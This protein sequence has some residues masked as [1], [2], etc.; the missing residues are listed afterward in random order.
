[1]SST[2][3]SDPRQDLARENL[4]SAALP[5][6]S[7]AELDE[8]LREL[9]ER[10]DDVVQDRKRLSLLLD[11]VVVIAAD[12]SLDSVLARIVRVASEL[13]DARYA[14][15]GVL[16]AGSERPLRAFIHHGLSEEQRLEIGELPQGHGLLGLIIDQPQPLRLH[17]IAAHPASYG[18]P[19][20]HPPMRSFL[21]VPIRI[22]DRVFGNLYLTEKSGAGDFSEADEAAV[23]ALAAAAGVVIENARLAEE[24]ARREDWLRATAEI[25]RALVEGADRL[26]T[27]QTLVDVAREVASADVALVTIRGRGD[28]KLEVPVV[29]GGSSLPSSAQGPSLTV[30]ASL[31][32]VVLSTGRSEMVDD[33]QWDD[34][35]ALEQ[36]PKD[37]P[38]LGPVMVVPMKAP[39]GVE[40]VL[41]LG[42]SRTRAAAYRELDVRLPELF[43]AQA[44][45]AMQVAQ[46][47]EDRERLAVFE[48]RDRIGRD[49]HD[50]V[51]QRLFAI[52]LGLE[53]A[54]RTADRPEVRQRL[55][56]AVDDIDD[57]IKDIRRSIFALSVP[58]Q[59]TDIRTTV[60]D[61]VYRLTKLLGFEPSLRFEGPV[62]S[63]VTSE[64][65][66]QLV[67][68]LG[69]ALTNVARHAGASKAWVALKAGDELVL[70]V[71]DD[72]RGVPPGVLQSGLRNMRQRAEDLG[73]HC[74]V[75]SEAGAG[76]VITW[77]IPA[78]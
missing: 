61:L 1:M 32:G 67:A 25:T 22:G 46:G 9:L 48:D 21:G 12:L 24:Q 54:I 19:P 14:A 18:F 60:M 16:G 26:D 41:T 38:E 70:T 51:I 29:S 59:S 30:D 3:S 11:A 10:V 13:A 42:W 52:G 62:N 5:A 53:G 27:L 76:T 17:D 4:P 66:P 8:L 31:A 15:L 74:T 75:D 7:V 65:A 71:G 68:V 77:S 2:D 37:W 47:R 58:T 6:L 45:L 40:G 28:D 36:M 20:H 35:V 50:L 49:L 33:I 73:G 56:S 23:V 44:A 69:E 57:T 34:R 39:G 72:G 43:A 55:T 64:T 78:R 63:I